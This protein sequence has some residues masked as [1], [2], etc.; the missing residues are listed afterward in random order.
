MNKL[1]ITKKLFIITSVIF[2]VFIAGTLLIQ[3]L[4]FQRFYVYRKKADLSSTIDKFKT[5]YNKAESDDQA[6]QLL[7]QYE[8]NGDIKIAILDNSNRIK[9]LTRNPN[10][11]TDMGK[12][13]ELTQFIQSWAEN[14]QAVS[15]FKQRNS[16]LTVLPRTLDGTV[17]NIVAISPDNQKSEVIFAIT[18]LQ[19]VNEAVSVIKDL[20]VYFG[21]GAVFIIVILSLIYSNMIAKPLVKIN[22]IATKMANLD[23]NEKCIVSSS[24]E[25]GNVAASLNFL[26]EN[27]NTAMNSLKEANAKLEL[28]IERERKLEKMRKEFVAAVSHELKTPITLIDGYAVGLKDNIFEGEDKDYYLDIIIDEAEKMGNLVSDMLD[29]SHL[30]SGSFKLSKEKFNLTELIKI[31][32][33]KYEPII[34]EKKVKVETNLLDEVLVFADWHRIEQILTNYITNAL[35][36]V[37]DNGSIFI[38]TIEEENDI[39]IEIENTGSNIPEEDLLKV[40]DRFYKVD[41][42]RNRRLGGTGIGLS[43]VKNI[44]MLHNY[45]FGARNTSLGVAFYF[46]VPK[47]TKI[48]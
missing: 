12:T 24:D 42:S 30:E 7:E 3:S 2:A 4:F 1:S 46:K 20:Y 11:R 38:K 28:D 47:N 16:S 17:K 13:R 41:K 6:G 5:E 34:D 48:K 40:W 45:S 14:P 37:E 19:P 33:N 35:R 44:L 32:L 27:L 25:I 26:S 21:I 36:H 39:S 31:T 23:F 8:I 9:L 18:S 22:R 15:D 43:I 10:N 29:L